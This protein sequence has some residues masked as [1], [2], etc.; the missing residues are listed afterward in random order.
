MR[1][2]TAGTGTLSEGRRLNV[3]FYM[4]VICQKWFVLCPKQ[5][6]TAGSFRRPK[7]KRFEAKMSLSLYE[8]R[9]VRSSLQ[10]PVYEKGRNC[11][12]HTNIH[13]IKMPP[14]QNDPNFIILSATLHPVG[15]T[16]VIST[17]IYRALTLG[18]ELKSQ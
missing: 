7:A 1:S 12:L 6:N 16:V 13:R 8:L 14:L 4:E 18:F 2:N 3:S 10:G 5:R 9:V 15:R 17:C 11:V